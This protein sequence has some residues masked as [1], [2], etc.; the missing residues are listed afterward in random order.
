MLCSDGITGDYGD[1]LMSDAEMASI[2]RG[3]R[4]PDDAAK[5]LVALARKKDDRTALVFG[6]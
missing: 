3:A 1:D 5:N 6:A 2:V 4:T